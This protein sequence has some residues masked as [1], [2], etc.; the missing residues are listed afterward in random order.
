MS[1]KSNPNKDFLR[2]GYDKAIIAAWNKSRGTALRYLG[3]PGP[4]LLDIKEWQEYLEFFT[5]I[6]RSENEQH[7]LFLNANVRDVEHRLHSLY[8]EFDRILL[9]GRDTYNHVPRWPYDLVNLD[10]FGGFIYQDL[11]RPRA[12]EKLVANQSNFK[13][14]FLMIITHDLRDADLTGEKRAFIDDVRRLLVRDHGSRAEINTAMDWYLAATTPDA[15]RQALYVNVVL[16]DLGEANH[17][18]VSSRPAI[19]YL[20]TG[21]TKMIHYVTDFHWQA[22]GYRAISDQSLMDVINLG[23]RELRQEQLVEPTVQPRVATAAAPAAE[24]VG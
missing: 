14:S 18:K 12:I 6:E 4:D 20:G 22:H 24:R 15:A 23:Y 21:G 5:T 2:A 11:S 9:S 17:F 16:R 8:G 7:R 10:F 3:L 1:F 19:T 13:R